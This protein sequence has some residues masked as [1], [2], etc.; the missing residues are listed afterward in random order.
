MRPV[1]IKRHLEPKIQA[2]AAQEANRDVTELVYGTAGAVV[3]LDATLF[4]LQAGKI[5]ELLLAEGFD[6][7]LR[8][9]TKC[10]LAARSGD[11]VCISCGSGRK[12][13]RLSEILPGLASAHRTKIEIVDGSA[14]EQLVNAGGIGGWLRQNRL[15]AAR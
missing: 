1:T 3:G 4:Q 9:C 12:S 11:P 13:V 7:D 14:S 2:R 5:S 15:A 6:S 8:Q 10:G